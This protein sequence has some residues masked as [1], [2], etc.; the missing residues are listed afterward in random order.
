MLDKLYNPAKLREQ[1][2][3]EWEAQHKNSKKEK[4]VNVDAVKVTDENGNEETISQKELNR[5]KLAAAR[6]AQAEK[7]GEEYHE[8][9]D[10]K[11]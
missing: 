5:R 1:A 8:D 9:D 10:D 6:K 11:K 4:T 3:A 2:A 7:Y